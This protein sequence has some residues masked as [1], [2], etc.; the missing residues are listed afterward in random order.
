M[1]DA[2]RKVLKA[3]AEIITRETDAGEKVILKGFGTFS[4][5]AK[6][7]RTARNPQ[8]GAAITVPARNVLVFKASAGTTEY[9]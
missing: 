4:R 2:D 9:K 6:A 7:A 5:K 1:L 3:A 8:T